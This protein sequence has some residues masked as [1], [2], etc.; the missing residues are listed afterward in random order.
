MPFQQLW[1][2]EISK[3]L[4]EHMRKIDITVRREA[5]D[6]QVLAQVIGAVRDPK[7]SNYQ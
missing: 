2:Q 6:G 4:S 5:K 3:T 1:Q 7:P